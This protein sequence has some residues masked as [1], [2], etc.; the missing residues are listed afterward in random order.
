LTIPFNVF[1]IPGAGG[2]IAVRPTIA[3]P[4]LFGFVFGPA[5]GFVSGFLGNILSDAVSFGGF[6]W[7][8]DIGNGL[9]GAIPGIGYFIVKRTDWTKVRGLGT[10]AVLAIAGVVVGI[11]FAAMTDFAFQIG[12][13]EFGAALTEFYSAGA[14]DAVNGAILTPILLYAYA[15]AT[16]GRARRV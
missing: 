7:N 13:T 11:G 3:I 8:W 1:Q 5:A 14:T 16:A 2:I 10:A 6:Y 12:L 9:I 15:K 4:I